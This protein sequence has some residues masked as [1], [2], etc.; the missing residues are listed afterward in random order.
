[1]GLVNQSSGRARH[2]ARC[3]RNSTRR[4]PPGFAMGWWL[5]IAVGQGVN[6]RKI[7]QGDQQRQLS[8]SHE[9]VQ[10]GWAQHCQREN[11]GSKLSIQNPIVRILPAKVFSDLQLN[12]TIQQKVRDEEAAASGIFRELCGD[13]PEDHS[14][15]HSTDGNLQ[16]TFHA[17]RSTTFIIRRLSSPSELERTRF[18]KAIAILLLIK[19]MLSISQN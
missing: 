3:S 11:D 13:E 5:S 4:S 17:V 1:M 15:G 7:A 2:L 10:Q 18:C 9:I 19:A 12:P 6:F 8:H 14:L 16:S